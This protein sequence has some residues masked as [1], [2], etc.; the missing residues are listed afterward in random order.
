MSVAILGGGFQGCCAA[1]ELAERGIQVTLYEQNSILLA[2]AATVNEGKI[3]LGYNYASDSSL[4]TVN[5]LLQGALSFAPKLQRYLD[6]DVS[7]AAEPF[8]YAVHRDSQIKVGDFAT[9]LAA[10]HS[11]VD[12]AAGRGSYFGID[13]KAPRRATRAALE[14]RFDPAHILAAFDTSEIAIN[15]LDLVRAMRGRIAHDPKINVRTR[16]KVTA[17]KEDGARLRVHSAGI[18]CDDADSDTFSNVVNALWDGRLAIDATLGIHPGRKWIYRFKHGIRFQLF[19]SATFPSVTIVL[20]PFGDLVTYGD[21]SYYIS[22]YPACMTAHSKALAPPA[23]RAEPHEPGLSKIV[24]ELFAAMGAIVPQLRSVRPQNL[25]VRGG[26]IVAWG[27]TD[28]DDHASELH[29]RHDIGVH[30]YGGY[31]SIDPGKL[32]MAPHFAKV[33]ADRIR[34]KSVP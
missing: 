29:R 18:D 7:L 34:L 27:S 19:D 20:G 13:L 16:R 1:I 15:V 25:A 5:T 22:W 17:V 10:T 12:A 9:H 6:A 33:C 31:H 3:Y 23:W 28:I 21:G 24:T 11:L 32:S 4:K 14:N 8:V 26:V 2:G 30:S